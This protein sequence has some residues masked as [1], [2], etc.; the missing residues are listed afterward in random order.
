MTKQEKKI[1]DDWHE[2]KKDKEK[3]NVVELKGDDIDKVLSKMFG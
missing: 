2:F 3:N 1:R